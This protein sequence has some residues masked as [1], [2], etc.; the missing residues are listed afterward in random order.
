MKIRK[1]RK[2]NAIPLAAMGDIAFLLLV[3]YMATTM[4]T[5]QKPRDIP[6]PEVNAGVK[7][8]PYPL[9]IYV[10]KEMA[11]RGSAFF[12]NKI[13][14]LSSLS[15]IVKDRAASA[16]A[17]VRVYINIDKDLPYK[18]MNEVINVLK[19]AGI[20]NLIITSRIEGLPDRK[21][22]EPGEVSP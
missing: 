20:R 15:E 9:I 17:S 2:L 13:V 5:D 22:I 7:N 19:E 11:A 6:L 18:H 21:A 14:P 10:D 16:P 3:F 4:V 12:F 8:S 1:K